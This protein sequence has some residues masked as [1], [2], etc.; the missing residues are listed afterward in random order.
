[1]CLACDCVPR[2]EPQL[3]LGSK[4][5]SAACI[6]GKVLIAYR[7]QGNANNKKRPA[8]EAAGPA[9]AAKQPKVE[10]DAAAA[11]AAAAWQQQQ[12]AQ[13]AAYGQQQQYYAGYPPAA[14]PAY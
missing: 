8:G 4:H 13:W 2:S 9:E 5:H 6:P 12:A 1:M 7:S 11:A 10:E 14:Y 3:R